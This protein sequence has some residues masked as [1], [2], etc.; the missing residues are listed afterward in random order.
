MQFYLYGIVHESCR[1][2]IHKPTN[3]FIFVS[4]HFVLQLYHWRIFLVW[5][6]FYLGVF[7][8]FMIIDSLVIVSVLLMFSLIPLMSDYTE[9]WSYYQFPDLFQSYGRHILRIFLLVFQHLCAFQARFYI[10][11]HNYGVYCLSF[12]HIAL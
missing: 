6:F 4:L 11:C 3:L 5:F 8:P 10:T 7:L 9:L 12:W 2:L 1:E